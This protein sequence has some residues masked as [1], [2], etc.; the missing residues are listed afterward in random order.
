ML[1]PGGA[2][3]RQRISDDPAILMWAFIM[4]MAFQNNHL[5]VPVTK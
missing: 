1:A 5:K 4:P 2:K 3:S